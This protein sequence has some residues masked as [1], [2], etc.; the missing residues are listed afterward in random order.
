MYRLAELT[1][2]VKNDFAEHIFVDFS[3]CVLCEKETLPGPGPARRLRV[4]PHGHAP[5]G[6]RVQGQ[7]AGVSQGRGRATQARL[8]VNT[9]CLYYP[10]IAHA[11]VQELHER[12][13]LVM[14]N[15]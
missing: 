15:V 13:V 2:H 4:G 6:P 7:G 5:A 8:I 14:T 9:H 1:C 11:T 10:L 12:C 3:F